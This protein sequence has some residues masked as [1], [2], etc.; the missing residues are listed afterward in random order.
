MRVTN[1]RI[2]RVRHFKFF[3][4]LPQCHVS[5][6]SELVLH[7]IL[8]RG[9]KRGNHSRQDLRATSANHPWISCC[10]ASR[11]HWQLFCCGEAVPAFWLQYQSHFIMRETWKS[12]LHQALA[13]HQWKSATSNSRIKAQQCGNIH[14]NV[15]DASVAATVLVKRICTC[16]CIPSVFVGTP[17]TSAIKIITAVWFATAV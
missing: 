14:L 3:P 15:S 2:H 6:S 9:R 7:Y 1:T 17:F 11:C 4:S 13:P 12:F 5:T 8:L 16:I 10:G